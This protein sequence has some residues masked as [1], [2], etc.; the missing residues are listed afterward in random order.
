MS[1]AFWLVALGVPHP[2]HPSSFAEELGSAHQLNELDAAD[3]PCPVLAVSRE[4][5][6]HHKSG[7][8][9]TMQ[10]VQVKRFRMQLLRL[11]LLRMSL[12]IGPT[13]SRGCWKT[14]WTGVHASRK[15]T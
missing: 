12:T 10:A 7:S 5:V 8:T 13:P 15:P 3:P 14:A 1:A 9:L 6:A 2:P 4:F 11:V